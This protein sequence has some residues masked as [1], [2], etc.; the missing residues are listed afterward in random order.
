MQHLIANADNRA[1]KG[2][3]DNY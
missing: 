2:I 3:V 1:V